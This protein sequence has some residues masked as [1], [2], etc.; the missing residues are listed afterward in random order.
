MLNW[1]TI[2]RTGAR[3]RRFKK[4]GDASDPERNDRWKTLPSQRTLNWNQIIVWLREMGRGNPPPGFGRE[5]VFLTAPT[6]ATILK[7]IG[8][9]PNR[10]RAGVEY[11]PLRTVCVAY[12][13]NQERRLI[14]LR[15]DGACLQQGNQL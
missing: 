8:I 3:V 9:L 12:P 14:T 6:E 2:P 1:A 7:L 15:L 10:G 4:T 13:L 11:A 5:G